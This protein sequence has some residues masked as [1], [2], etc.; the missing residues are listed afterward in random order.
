MPC[1]RLRT[2]QSARPWRSRCPRTA[3]EQ[4]PWSPDPFWIP[5]KR[6]RNR[7]SLLAAEQCAATAS[8]PAKTRM[9]ALQ[10]RGVPFFQHE[11]VIVGQFFPRLDVAQ[12]FDVNAAVLID[13][14]T[15][16]TARMIDEA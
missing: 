5:E 15:I 8:R 12:R 4:R 2:L 13:R 16:G 10:R 11:V 14:F 9:C 3:H 6:S 7:D 1:C